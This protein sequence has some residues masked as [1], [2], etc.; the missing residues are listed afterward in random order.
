MDEAESATKIG[1]RRFLKLTGA[2]GGGMLLAACGPVDAPRTPVAAPAVSPTDTPAPTPTATVRPAA[3]ASIS[4][5]TMSGGT[6]LQMLPLLVAQEL[7]LEAEGIALKTVPFPGSGGAVRA[8]IA[9][10]QQI[11]HP[12]PNSAAVAAEQ[13]QSIRI[14]ANNLP[15][16]SIVWAIRPDSP[17]KSMKDLKGRRL[18]YSRSGSISQTYAFAALRAVGLTPNQD[19]TMIAAGSVT[20]QLAGIQAGTLDAGWLVD[21]LLTQELLKKTVRVLSPSY[22]LI[23]AWSESVLVTTANY[24]K[25]NGELLRA[26]LRA[27]QRAMDFIKNNPDK[28]AEIWAKSQDIAVDVAQAALKAYPVQ[29]FTSRIDPPALKAIAADMLANKQIQQAPDWSQI[30]DQSFLALELRAPV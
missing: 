11:G 17:L 6:G 12:A 22:E 10:G 29:R 8:V 16:P 24:A 19:V 15:F 7:F 25:A 1:R 4:F 20:D 5:A 13:G 26:Y 21:P 18:G 28:S 9:S 23:P 27:H 2:V 3:S 14:I 30:V